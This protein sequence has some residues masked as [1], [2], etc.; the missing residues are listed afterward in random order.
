MGEAVDVDVDVDVVVVV[1]DVV[2][3]AAATAGAETVGMRAWEFHLADLSMKTTAA[4][5]E[6]KLVAVA[7]AVAV[8][9]EGHK[10]PP[11]RSRNNSSRHLQGQDVSWL[12]VDQSVLKGTYSV[13]VA[14]QK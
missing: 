7:A 14:V 8:G 12:V 10:N 5:L 13:A 1:V 3:V 6:M 9:E 4:G 2:V 11:A